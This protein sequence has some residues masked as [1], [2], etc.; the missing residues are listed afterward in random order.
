MFRPVRS[1]INRRAAAIIATLTAAAVNTF[2]G[3][4]D[5]ALPALTVSGAGTFTP[6]TYTGTSGRS[7]RFYGSNTADVD[8]V[9]I[10]LTASGGTVATGANVGSGDFTYEL[11]IRC[12]YADNDSTDTADWRNSNIILDRDIWN[13]SRGHGL[14]VSRSGGNLVPVFGVAGAS[15]DH[16]SIAGTTNVGDGNWHHIVIDRNASTGLIR[17]GV[18]GNFEDSR[19][20]VTSTLAYPTSYT[21]TGGQDNE[22]IVLSKEKHDLGSGFNGRI[23]YLRLSTSR[24]FTG[25]TYHI[26]DGYPAD[27]G[28]TGALYRFDDGAGTTLS[29]YASGNTDGTLAVGGVSNGPTWDTSGPY[30]MR[31]PALT[32][33]GAATFTPPTYSATGDLTLPALTL[34][35]SGEFDTAVFT[36]SGDLVLPALTV[37]GSGDF[38]APVYSASGALNLP[39]LT[40]AGAGDHDAPV[41]SAT[42]D[43]V[44]PALT[45]SGSGLFASAVYSGSGDLSLPALTLSGAGDFDAPTYSGSGDLA[46]PALVASGV[47][48]FD[49]PVYTASGALTLPALTVAGSGTFVAAFAGSGDLILPAVTLDGT[50]TFVAPT[51]T[52]SGDLILPALTVAGVGLF[53]GDVFNGSGDLVLP[54]LTLAGSGTFEEAVTIP[55][56]PVRS[57]GRRFGLRSGPRVGMRGSKVRVGPR[58]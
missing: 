45:L 24:R 33:S 46:L 47:G 43:A 44:L 7:L 42:G 27:D 2:T 28:D 20:Y 26:P 32:L 8:R 9:R 15:L 48:D 21:P 25:S 40:I 31:L 30:G 55:V 57:L 3:S 54:A 37:S 12:A 36:G 38:D 34:S 52:G 19:T 14:G 53:A 13:D 6:P 5:L 39:A 16:L 51:Y 29:D 41:Y 1:P 10:P 11:W 35:G 22:Y 56:E 58:G 4:G 50:G 23:G 18:D 17:I 49:A